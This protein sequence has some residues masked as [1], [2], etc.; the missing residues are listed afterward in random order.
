MAVRA[1]EIA[2]HCVGINIVR[3]LDMGT[4]TTSC[5]ELLQAYRTHAPTTEPIINA[6][7]FLGMEIERDRERRIILVRV[8]AKIMEL[9]E[10]FWTEKG[11]KRNVPMPKDGYIVQEHEIESL[12][13]SM[14]E[15]LTKS[16]I[17]NY[18]SIVGCLIWIQGVRMDIIFLY[19]I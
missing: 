19:Y 4:K 11:V 13:P 1:I 18:L 9:C 14:K 15:L 16:E 2:A 10:E 12:S 5:M 3:P 8:Q 6:D 17:S 7:K